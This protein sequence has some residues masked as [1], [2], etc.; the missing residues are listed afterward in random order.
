MPTPGSLEVTDGTRKTM[1]LKRKMAH[2]G[3]RAKEISWSAQKRLCGR[4][5]SLVESGKNTKVVCVAVARE[6]V[7]YVWDLVCCEMQTSRS[8]A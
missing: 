8:A 6:L 5:R 4:Y 3:E 1:Y 2:A 7:G